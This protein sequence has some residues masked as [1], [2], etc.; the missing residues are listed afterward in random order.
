MENMS[1]WLPL[2]AML[3]CAAPLVIGLSAAVYLA[4]RARRVPRAGDDRSAAR[5]LLDHRLATGE[6]SPEEYFERE[7]ALRSAEPSPATRRF[8]G[9]GR[10]LS[11]THS[12]L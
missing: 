6:I 11:S 3:A 5:G 12:N 7:S 1:S 4:G 9:G 10:I 8:A 2:L